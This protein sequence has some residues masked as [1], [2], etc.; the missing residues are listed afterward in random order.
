MQMTLT[1][2][3][4]VL[5][6]ILTAVLSMVVL[7]V[8]LYYGSAYQKARQGLKTYDALLAYE[9]GQLELDTTSDDIQVYSGMGYWVYVQGDYVI[10]ATD[11]H[12]GC[13]QVFQNGIL[14]AVTTAPPMREVVRLCTPFNPH[15]SFTLHVRSQEE[16][17]KI[18]AAIQ[19]Q[20]RTYLRDNDYDYMFINDKYLVVL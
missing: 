11:E 16:A 4:F 5:I 9:Q 8:F 1:R 17:N 20:G 2:K 3:R 19:E 18:S 10:Q 12:T 7:W 13:T 6:L 15:F 14:R